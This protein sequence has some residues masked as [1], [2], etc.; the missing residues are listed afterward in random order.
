MAAT[1]WF[2]FVGDEQIGPIATEELKR[3]AADGTISPET[4][5]WNEGMPSRRV[6]SAL[7]GLF[8]KSGPGVS[9]PP[10]S[11]KSPEAV[12]TALKAS[13]NVS[14]KLWFLDLKFEQF[15]TPR[16]IG[17]L[18]AASLLLLVLLGVG[19]IGYALLNYP[20]LQAAIISVVTIIYLFI[21]AVGMRVFFE[22]CLLMFR[23]TEH[24]SNLRHLRPE[25]DLISK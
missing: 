25:D 17:F 19:S 9:A 7:N 12:R 14:K 10:P 15:A 18:F 6:A 4:E 8:P 22:G 13:D 16:L 3:L 1:E 11:R 2:Y 20:V 21:L 23:M 24:L 5:V